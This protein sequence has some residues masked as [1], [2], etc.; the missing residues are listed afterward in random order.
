[1]RESF[2]FYRSFYESIKEL[3]PTLQVEI[4]H[5]VSEYSLYGNVVEMSPVCKA[6]FTAF[7]PSINAAKSRYEA[8]VEN[9]KK[10]AEHGKKGGAPKGNSNASKKNNPSRNEKTTPAE[11]PK[12]T[13]KQPQ[14]LKKQPLTDTVTDTY[15]DNY[16]SKKVSTESAREGKR[17]IQSYQ[18]IMDDTEVPEIMRPMLWSFI[19]HCQ[20]NKRTLTNDKLTGIIIKLDMM[21]QEDVDKIKSLKKAIDGGYFDVV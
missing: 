20:L 17:H 4:L 11:T 7:C 15:T 14:S 19:Q 21:Y 12:T 8:C 9:G 5:A 18:E 13:P 16:V 6:L 1:M 2:I 3:E 10:G